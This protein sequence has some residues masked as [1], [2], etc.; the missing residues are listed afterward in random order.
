MVTR[1]HPHYPRISYPLWSDIRQR[2]VCTHPV[3]NETRLPSGPSLGGA[4]RPG[5][6]NTMIDGLLL[7][8]QETGHEQW[9]CSDADLRRHMAN[10][11]MKLP[12]DKTAPSTTAAYIHDISIHEGRESE[13]SYFRSGSGWQR[14]TRGSARHG[15]GGHRSWGRTH[16]PRVTTHPGPSSCRPSPGASERGSPGRP[17]TRHRVVVA[18]LLVGHGHVDRVTVRITTG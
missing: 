8:D 16:R 18:P 13:R 5:G 7:P 17:T 11:I 10:E 4:L 15:E 1:C 14:P 9:N 12:S 3:G 6:T 2:I